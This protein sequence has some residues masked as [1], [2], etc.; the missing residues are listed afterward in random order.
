MGGSTV[1]G[2]RRC[3]ELSSGFEARQ[4]RIAHRQVRERQESKHRC[5]TSSAVF[6]RRAASQSLSKH[7]PWIPTVT[8]SCTVKGRPTYCPLKNTPFSR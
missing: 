2:V 4:E 8:L 5:Q 7:D 3:A 1:T 6:P